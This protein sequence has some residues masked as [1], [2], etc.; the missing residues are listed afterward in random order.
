MLIMPVQDIK[1]HLYIRT[2]YRYGDPTRNH[3]AVISMSDI[4]TLVEMFIE[5]HFR[6]HFKWLVNTYSYDDFEHEFLKKFS[7]HVRCINPN[8]SARKI[9]SFH[10][11][12]DDILQRP[13]ENRLRYMRLHEKTRYIWRVE[14]DNL[15][16]EDMI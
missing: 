15:I 5:Q 4:D 8:V 14:G 13:L 1:T 2:Q 10:L 11:M 3:L 16:V 12:L 7:M 6:A 9:N